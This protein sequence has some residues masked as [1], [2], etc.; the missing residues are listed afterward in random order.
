MGKL[1]KPSEAGYPKKLRS[2][3][4]EYY[5]ET[6]R[7][8]E[9][10]LSK[11]SREFKFARNNSDLTTYVNSMIATNG[12]LCNLAPVQYANGRKCTF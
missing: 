2:Q 4:M 9:A 7:K 6:A 8:N 12:I 3:T 10:D 11:E 5:S 1:I